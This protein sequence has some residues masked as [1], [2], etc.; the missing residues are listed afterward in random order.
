MRL[1]LFLLVLPFLI[2]CGSKSDMPDVFD[3]KGNKVGLSGQKYV[4][5]F[6]VPDCPWA[7]RY[8]SGFEALSKDPESD[9]WKFALILPGKDYKAADLKDFKQLTGCSLPIYRDPEFQLT[10]WAKASIS[11][12]FFVID[13]QSELK[14]GGAFDNRVSDLGTYR[15]EADTFFVQQA[16]ARLKNNSTKGTIRTKAIGCYLE[17]E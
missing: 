12:E 16:M 6:M 5:M 3:S 4:L 14:Y 1:I 2:G 10:K 7:Q 17:Y 11:P 15:A 13:A 9:S 8:Y